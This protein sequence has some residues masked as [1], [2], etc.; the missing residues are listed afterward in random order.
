MVESTVILK[1][2]DGEGLSTLFNVRTPACLVSNKLRIQMQGILKMKMVDRT[3]SRYDSM[4]QGMETFITY[5][6]NR[7]LCHIFL[8]S[9]GYEEETQSKGA[10]TKII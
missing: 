4:C 2:A 1:Q 10:I 3:E 6:T 9:G 5:H 8:L 7:L